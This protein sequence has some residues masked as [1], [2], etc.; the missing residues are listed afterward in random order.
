[1][2]KNQVLTFEGPELSDREWGKLFVHYFNLLV[3]REF[4]LLLIWVANIRPDL[5]VPTTHELGLIAKAAAVNAST[6]TPSGFRASLDDAIVALELYANNPR[7]LDPPLLSAPHSAV[8]AFAELIAKLP[9]A[10]DRPIF[11]C[12]DEYENLLKGQQSAL[13]T[14][15]KHSTTPLSYKLGVRSNGLYS[16][17]TIDN[18]DQL[19]T[20]DD[21]IEIYITEEGFELFAERVAEVRLARVADFEPRV[22]R[23]IGDF[24]PA[25]PV[26]EEA[27]LLGV[28]RITEDVLAQLDN[29]KFANLRA[30]VSSQTPLRIALL[31]YW[32]EAHPGQSLSS[33]AADWQAHPDTWATR[34]GNYNHSVLFWLS[35]GR[36]GAHIKKY[37]T[38]CATFLAMASGNIRYFMELLDRSIAYQLANSEF[39]LNS[40]ALSSRAQTMAAK[41]VG[42]KRLEQLEGVSGNGVRLKR[43][44]LGIGRV[45]FE[46]TRTPGMAPEQNAFTVGG[47]PPDVNKVLDLLADGVGHLAFESFAR[48]K[49]TSGTEPGD[50]E[51]RIH[52][53]YSALFE[54]SHRRKRRIAFDASVLLEL[55]E[56]PAAG[57]SKLLDN[58]TSGDDELP[59]QLGLFAAFFRENPPSETPR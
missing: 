52:P 11:C 23:S 49:R 48:S 32:C 34:F 36:K 17:A 21:Y 18:A 26:E 3:C 53:I 8:R 38:G 7:R 15:V 31:A 14:Y 10:S 1:M 13:N 27:Q 5:P 56:S 43:L 44:V 51:Y 37:Y 47:S 25:L 19:Q 42:Q 12:I 35:R 9:W 29:D 55:I 50:L 40:F 41:T 4:C 59:E 2:D 54:I 28:A 24:L 45:F 46:R 33:L 39:E 22:P 30:F 16:R 58:R 20:P 6:P 57:I